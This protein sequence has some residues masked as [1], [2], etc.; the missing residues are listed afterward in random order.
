MTKILRAAAVAVIKVPRF[1]GGCI[2]WSALAS[3]SCSTCSK[4]DAGRAALPETQADGLVR[5][6]LVLDAGCAALLE[7]LSDLAIQR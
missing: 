1:G 3:P 5:S 7:T 2:R 4:R 6:L